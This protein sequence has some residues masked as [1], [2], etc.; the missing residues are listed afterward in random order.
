MARSLSYVATLI[1]RQGLANCMQYE[2]VRRSLTDYFTEAIKRK[3]QRMGEFG[4]LTETE[5]LIFRSGAAYGSDDL[6]FGLEGR[7]QLTSFQ[8]WAGIQAPEGSDDDKL[9]SLEYERAYSDYCQHILDYDKSL[10]KYDFSA[11]AISSVDR[12]STRSPAYPLGQVIKTFFKDQMGERHW[13]P[14]TELDKRQQFDLLQEILGEQTDIRDVLG[15]QARKVK[16][17]VQKFPTNRNKNPVTRGRSLDEV[18]ELENVKKLSTS[19][20]NQYL[21]SYSSLFHWAKNQTYIEYNFFEGLAV[22]AKKKGKKEGRQSFDRAQFQKMLNEILHNES[23]LIKKPYQ[24]WGP[25]IAMYTGARLNEIAQLALD[26]IKFEE[27]LHCFDFNENTEDKKLKNEASARTVPLHSRLVSEGLLQHVEECQSALN[28]GSDSNLLQVCELVM[29]FFE[30]ESAA[31]H[32]GS[33]RR[34][35]SRQNLR[36][37]A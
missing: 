12:P 26:D 9:I 7:P 1:V 17:T 5:A 36:W 8:K 10:N 25:L 37:S 20:V 4:R 23:G 34:G 27:G 24:K 22:K 18:I 32:K 3:K 16:S 31:C 28:I 21:Q 11:T 35:L 14:K 6:A 29:L 15:E 19:T 33:R 13:G 30:E 2:E